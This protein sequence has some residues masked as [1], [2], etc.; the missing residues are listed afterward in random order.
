MRDVDSDVNNA[1]FPARVESISRGMNC[2]VAHAVQF[3]GTSG[4]RMLRPAATIGRS[5]GLTPPFLLLRA[6]TRAIST[7]P[8][9]LGHGKKLM[10]RPRPTPRSTPMPADNTRKGP[11]KVSLIVKE[12]ASLVPMV[13]RFVLKV[14]PDMVHSSGSDVVAVNQAGIQEFFR[15][16]DSLK[17]RCGDDDGSADPSSAQQQRQP[18]KTRYNLSFYYRPPLPAVILA[19]LGQQAGELRRANVDITVPPLFQ[20]RMTQ[21]EQRGQLKQSRS[22]WLGF[23]MDSLDKLLCAVGVDANMMLSPEHKAI[24]EKSAENASKARHNGGKGGELSSTQYSG[25]LGAL[26]ANLLEY[27]PLLQGKGAPFPTVG[28]SR[29]SVFSM[30]ERTGRALSLLSDRGKIL[31]SSSLTG[32]QVRRAFNELRAAFTTYHDAL[33]LYHPLWPAVAVNLGPTGVWLAQPGTRS[34]HVPWDFSPSELVAFV[35]RHLPSLVASA[36]KDVPGRVAAQARA[37][38][39]SKRGRSTGYSMYYDAASKA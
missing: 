9:A 39:A 14:H 13:K 21:L 34:L 18:L 26:R 7:D 2:V 25:A 27:S 33:Q 22:E 24:V 10:K 5:S 3:A 35:Q 6:A 28:M 1:A 31:P 19:D 15:L 12:Y 30:K 8:Q 23:A 38:K 32:E 37:T 11:A 4:V 36:N 29:D 16:F 17:P 20:E